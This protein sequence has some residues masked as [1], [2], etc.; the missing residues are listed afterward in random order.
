MAA[1]YS[2]AALLHEGRLRDICGLRALLPVPAL[3]L[4]LLE[5]LP[6]ATVLSFDLGDLPWARASDALLRARYGPE[7]FPG[8]VFGDAAQKIGPYFVAHPFKCDAVFVDG[9]KSYLGRYH[10][11]VEL[12]DVSRADAYVFMD[13]VTREKHHNH[14]ADLALSHTLSL[15][16]YPLVEDA[17]KAAIKD[18]QSKKD[19]R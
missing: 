2:A 18:Y 3:A 1:V 14:Q 7:R 15:K 11:L 8:V 19:G 5:A 16:H 17:I 4:L 13:E 10:S 6:S 12:R 9:D